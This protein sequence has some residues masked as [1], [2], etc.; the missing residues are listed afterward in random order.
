MTRH[1]DICYIDILLIWRKSM[2]RPIRYILPSRQILPNICRSNVNLTPT[3]ALHY[4]IFQL[5]NVIVG[6]EHLNHCGLLSFICFIC[7]INTASVSFYI[8]LHYINRDW[9]EIII[10]I[11]T[12]LLDLYSPGDRSNI[13]VCPQK[14]KIKPI[15]LL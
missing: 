10:F 9:K 12:K 4:L 11:I 2:Q 1:H 13:H 5:N 15:F 6:Q 8:L 3:K 7:M 14:R